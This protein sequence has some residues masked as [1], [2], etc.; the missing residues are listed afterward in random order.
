MVS[1]EGRCCCRDDDNGA[2]GQRVTQRRVGTPNAA[3]TILK[4]VPVQRSEVTRGIDEA[5]RGR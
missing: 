2:F 5:V 1:V 3:E 4:S